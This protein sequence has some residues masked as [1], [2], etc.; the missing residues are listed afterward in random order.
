MKH[1]RE[2][3]SNVQ[4]ITTNGT[5]RRIPEDEPVF[6]IRGQDAVGADT[7]RDWA[8][9]AEANGADPEIVRVARE[10]AAKMDAWPN[11]KTPDLPSN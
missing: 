1:A 9:R 2:D 8:E 5:T 10:H 4:E 11:K 7:V 3:Y 6:L